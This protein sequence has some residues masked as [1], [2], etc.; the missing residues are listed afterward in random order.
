MGLITVSG[1]QFC[2]IN[3]ATEILTV[4][5]AHFAPAQLSCFMMFLNEIWYSA[6]TS[7]LLSE[8]R[9]RSHDHGVGVT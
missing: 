5:H 2:V 9:G 3:S 8:N 1:T 4:D 6:A 7:P